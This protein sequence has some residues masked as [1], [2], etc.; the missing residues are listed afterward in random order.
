[1]T[2][3]AQALNAVP[4]IPG[5][6]AMYGGVPPRTWVAYVGQAGN[7]AQRLRQHLERRDSSVTTG[8]SAVGLNVDHVTLVTWWVHPA[9][10]DKDYRLAAELIRKDLVNIVVASE[11]VLD[12]LRRVRIDEL[13]AEV[14]RL[15]AGGAVR[16]IQIE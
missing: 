8:T 14:E 12:R 15:H 11:N 3:I 7:L 4:K 2:I 16:H 5:L 1:M 10:N 9:F 6:Y 13:L